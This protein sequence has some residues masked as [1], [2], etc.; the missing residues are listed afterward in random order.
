MKRGG[1]D[2]DLLDGVTVDDLDPRL[3][4]QFGIPGAV[5]GAVVTEVDPESPAARA[6]L[7]PGDIIMEINRRPVANADEAVELSKGLAGGRV[8]LRVWS[9]GGSRFIVVGR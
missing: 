2:G 6:G 5:D 8:L 4:R 9:R 7:Q 3:R 1:P